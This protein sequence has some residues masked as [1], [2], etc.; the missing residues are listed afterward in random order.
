MRLAG[1]KPDDFTLTAAIAA[2]S[3]LRDLAT[4]AMLHGLAVR[5]GF[6]T[7]PVS[8]SVVS[9][10]GKCSCPSDTARAFE[11]ME[12]RNVVSWCSLLHAY[13][14]SGLLQHALQLFGEMPKKNT[15]AW[16]VLIMGSALCNEPTMSMRLFREMVALGFE[17]DALTFSGLMNVCAEL[18][19]PCSGH[20]VHCMIS[21]VGWIDAVEVSNS[22]ISFYAA[23]G[24]E[25]DAVKVFEAMRTQSQVSWNAMIDAHM[26]VGNMEKALSLFKEAPS[27]NLISWTSVV[28]GFVE[29]GLR[30][31]AL[32]AFINMMKN[33]YRPDDL[34][35]GAALQACAIVAVLGYGKMVH[36]CVIRFGFG[37]FAYVANGMVNMYAKCGDIEGSSM[38][39]NG[40]C[41][42]DVVSWNTMILGFALHGRAL[43]ALE[44]YKEMVASN[45]RPDKVT[46]VGLLM[47]CS[48][49]GLLEEA[50]GFIDMMES[51]H[52]VSPDADHATCIV[53]ML[54]RA[55]HLNE[56]SKLIVGC[57]RFVSDK[58]A[59]P[60]E[61][62][63]SACTVTG[64]LAAGRE[65]GERLVGEEPE[66]DAG[67]VMLSNLYA[68]SG[69]WME[70]E[71][72][73]KKMVKQRVK[74]EPG[75]SWIEVRD[76][77]KVFTS[78]SRSLTQMLDL[79]DML[80]CLQSEMRNPSFIF[81]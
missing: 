50:R 80:D 18:D 13:T 25:K 73:R 34:M 20:M 19:D 12:Q 27:T 52:G 77:V 47:A 14:N 35:F 65:V 10:Y 23:F 5:S 9:M 60:S 78:G 15:V 8:N 21:K 16:N 68:V 40:I 45:V 29:N 11:A 76:V 4:G 1:A 24:C 54:G 58:G 48:H 37:S 26:K 42:R 66:N 72:V 17:S 6:D 46:F 74:K 71:R 70:A 36:G 56:A 81:L 39:F 30:E 79:H 59:N 43:K 67:Y 75:C 69:Q 7:L 31:E 62:L 3:D 64:D 61:A 22:I 28:M 53:D 55:G 51:A 32:L 38:V 49:S 33:F 44:M 2:A 63:L 57:S 41:L